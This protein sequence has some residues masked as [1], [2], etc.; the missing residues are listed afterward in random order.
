M[1]LIIFFLLSLI[2][3]LILIYFLNKK[4]IRKLFYKSNIQTKDITKL[5]KSFE[6]NTISNNLKGPKKEAIIKSFNITSDNDIVGMTSDYEA[7]ILSTLS[8]TSNNIFEFGTCSGKTTYLMALN[9]SEDTKITSLT[10]DPGYNT[11]LIKD[12]LDSKISHRNIINES[13]Y[14]KFLFSGTNVENKIKVIFGNSL[15][16]DHNIL[17]NKI[18]LVFIDGGHTYSIVKNDTEKS[19]D[20]LKSNGIIIWHDYVPGKKSS[21]DIVKY[22]NEISKDKKIYQIKNTSMCFYKKI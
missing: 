17:K 15:E 5:H 18:D 22:L 10:L 12:D 7:W 11:E 20:M 3:N 21:K 6:L 9:S 4:K 8:K 19:F 16:F 2:F 14:E 13:I 1:N